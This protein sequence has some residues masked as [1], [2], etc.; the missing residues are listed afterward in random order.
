[1]GRRILS[2]ATTV[3]TALLSS[4][5]C[6][7]QLLLNIFSYSCAG[8]AVFTPYRSY[9]TSTTLI[10]L[11]L[12]FFKSGWKSRR[13]WTTTMISLLLMVTP[14]IVS[15]LNIGSTTTIETSSTMVLLH[16]DGL[17]CLACA[18]RI[19]NALA[20]VDWVESVSVFF[21]NSSAIIQC[22]DYYYD[23]SHQEQSTI[24]AA[25]VQVIKSVDPKYDASLIV[26]GAGAQGR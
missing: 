22:N 7:I 12:L 16:L 10:F 2:D 24:A 9:L 13:A 5:C 25:L 19:K 20:A 6:I 17:G 18:N 1:M 21:D 11:S 15:W 14:E 8:F 26:P 23:G 4:S 3:V